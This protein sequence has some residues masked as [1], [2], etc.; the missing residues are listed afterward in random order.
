MKL[1]ALGSNL[2]SPLGGPVQN[3]QSALAQIWSLGWGITAKSY[4]YES[5]PV[6]VSDQPWFVNGVVAVTSEDA[7]AVALEKLLRIEN[8]MGRVR[9]QKNAAR[10]V[11]LDILAWD[12]CRMDGDIALPHPRMHVRAFVLYPLCDIAHHWRHPTLGETAMQMRDALPPS[13]IRVAKEQW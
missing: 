7:P 3:L 5:A 13:D 9:S 6:P 11:D 4:L 12:D 1:I 10:I 2:P 8:D